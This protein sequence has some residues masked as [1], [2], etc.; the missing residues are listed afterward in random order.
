LSFLLDEDE[1]QPVI[2][3]ISIRWL[4]GI[5][6]SFEAASP[7]ADQTFDVAGSTWVRKN[8]PSF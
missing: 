2:S 1:E 4:V 8:V 6:S 3:Q 5:D 7:P